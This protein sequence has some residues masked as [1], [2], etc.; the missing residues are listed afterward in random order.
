MN[1]LFNL[2]FLDVKILSKSKIFYLKLILFPC[3]L[4]LILGN[5][6][7]DQST[8]LTAFH[9]A[10]YSE[11]SSVNQD[12]LDTCLG[13]TFLNGVLESQDMQTIFTVTTVSSYAEGQS[14]VN[15]KKAAVFI[16]IPKDFTQAYIDNVDT[17]IDLI[18]DNTKQIEQGIVKDIIDRFRESIETIRLEQN[19]VTQNITASN[20]MTSNNLQAIFSQIQNTDSYSNEITKVSTGKNTR[21]IDIM[22]Y[23]AIAMV[24][25]FSILTAFELAH[26]IVEDKINHTQFRIKSTPILNIQYALGKIFGMVLA[27]VVQMSVVMI[28]SHFAFHV[29]FGNI[30]YILLTTLSYGFAIGSIVFCA[31]TAAKDQMSISS[32]ASIILYGLSF[33]GGSFVDKDSLPDS[34][35]IVQRLIPNGKAINCYVKICQ[36]GSI[37]DIYSDLIALMV[38]GLVFLVIALNLYSE[39]RISKNEDDDHD[40]ISIKAAI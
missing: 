1:Q 10:F 30:F 23:E 29:D 28:I 35:K 13:D 27:I 36:G 16:Y 40:K 31:G 37:S 2:I 15:D 3:I 20:Q 11:D 39:R 18:G 19:E 38:I 24:V 32:F 9:V 4:I 14:L 34:L 22:Q 25:M 17:N 21:P 6:F 8:K 5:I 7:G 33:F 26:G 12:S